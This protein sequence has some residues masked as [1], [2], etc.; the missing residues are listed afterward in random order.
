MDHEESEEQREVESDQMDD[1]DYVDD[2][3]V[4]S[5][6]MISVNDTSK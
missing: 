5:D 1:E 4:E 3:A 6:V 2:T